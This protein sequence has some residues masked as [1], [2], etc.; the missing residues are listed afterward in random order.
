MLTSNSRGFPLETHFSSIATK[1]QNWRSQLQT[2]EHERLIVSSLSHHALGA[3]GAMKAMT[4]QQLLRLQNW[5]VTGIMLF[6]FFS[7]E[8]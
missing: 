4:L 5:C 6:F 1:E 7:F 2:K 3:F 8:L